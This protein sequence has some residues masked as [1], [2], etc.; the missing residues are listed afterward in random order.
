MARY[1]SPVL[2]V[3]FDGPDVP[4][5]SLYRLLR[6]MS[7]IRITKRVYLMISSAIWQ[8]PRHN[9]SLSCSCRDF[10]VGPCQLP[11]PPRCHLC[12]EHYPRAQDPHVILRCHDITD[13]LLATNRCS[14]RKGLH[15]QPP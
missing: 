10:A 5:E 15:C 7:L 8:N 9:S 3:A 4:E 13:I 2:R 14:R 11:Q 12:E 1:V 6:V